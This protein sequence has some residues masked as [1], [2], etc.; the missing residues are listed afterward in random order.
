MKILVADDH[1][2]VRKGLCEI[3]SNERSIEEVREAASGYEVVE[4]AR[5][6]RFSV[7]VLEVSMPGLN[8]IE[9]V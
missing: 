2:V 3:I 8:G 1:P 9:T 6:E 4:L 5:N 7:I